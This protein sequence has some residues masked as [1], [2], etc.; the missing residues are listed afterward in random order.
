MRAWISAVV[1]L[2]LLSCTR[3]EQLDLARLQ[4]PRGFHIAIFAEAPH[5]R[6]LVFSPGGVLLAT[7][8]NDGKVLRMETRASLALPLELTGLGTYAAFIAFT[9]AAGALFQ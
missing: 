9:Y 7:S 8:A 3:A 1:P 5:A 4:V 6:M 2:V